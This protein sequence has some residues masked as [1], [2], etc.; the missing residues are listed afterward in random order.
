MSSEAERHS[1]IAFYLCTICLMNTLLVHSCLVV[2]P[3]LTNMTFLLIS[4]AG[5]HVGSQ[6]LLLS[7]Y[8]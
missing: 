6:T 8:C 4:L 5:V 2:L 1:F 3:I 7:R